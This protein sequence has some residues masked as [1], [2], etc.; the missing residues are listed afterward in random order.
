MK[1]L[2]V[3]LMVLTAFSCNPSD[4]K[5]RKMK[6]V[7]I[8]ELVTRRTKKDGGLEEV[9]NGYSALKSICKGAAWFYR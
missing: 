1:N 7:K 5:K 9:K 8:I 4:T 6:Q 2:G 3:G